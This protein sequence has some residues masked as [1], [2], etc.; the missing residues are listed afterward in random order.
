ME[1]IEVVTQLLS[2][3]ES[4]KS[5]LKALQEIYGDGEGELPCVRIV[6]VTDKYQNIRIECT[7]ENE[8]AL[9]EFIKAEIETLTE[10]L[11]A[12]EE[13]LRAVDGFIR[14]GI[15]SLPEK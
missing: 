2:E 9:K 11:H 7:Q 13:M 12:I 5:L 1:G 8:E 6:V 15:S 3:Y 4:K 10:D 14:E